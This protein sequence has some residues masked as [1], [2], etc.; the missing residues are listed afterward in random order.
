MVEALE[1]GD[2]EKVVLCQQNRMRAV[3]VSLEMFAKLGTWRSV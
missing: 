3:L 1:G 2:L